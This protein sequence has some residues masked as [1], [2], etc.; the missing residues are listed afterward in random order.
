MISS[1]RD[2]WPNQQGYRIADECTA[3]GD[4]WGGT[5]ISCFRGVGNGLINLGFFDG[6]AKGVKPSAAVS[7]DMFDVY[8]NSPDDP[9]GYAGKNY[10]LTNIPKIK[11]WKG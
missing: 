8:T 5:G 10:I 4:G 7:A 2:P 9:N 3:D 11:E 1:T 6:H